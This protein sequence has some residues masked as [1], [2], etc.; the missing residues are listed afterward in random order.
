MEKS[1]A[2]YHRAAAARARR[3]RAEATTR[4]LKEHLEGEIAW[5]D[6]KLEEIERA[7][8]VG[9]DEEPAESA[10]SAPVKRNPRSLIGGSADPAWG[11]PDNSGLSASDYSSPRLEVSIS[12][13]IS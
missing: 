9:S 6:Q 5:H 7:S 8:K 2:A 1:S 4:W 11:R 13:I 3:L 12:R 10:T